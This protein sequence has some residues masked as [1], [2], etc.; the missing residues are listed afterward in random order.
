MEAHRARSG[1]SSM[2]ILSDVIFMSSIVCMYVLIGNEV[3]YVRQ[4]TIS[5]S[6][7]IA[8]EL[9]FIDFVNIKQF[10][11]FE[12]GPGMCLKFRESD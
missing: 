3:V 11:I 1:L 8:V 5:Q 7:H 2:F 10:K 6:V 9:I 4:M 12:E